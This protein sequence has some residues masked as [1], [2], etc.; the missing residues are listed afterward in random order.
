MGDDLAERDAHGEEIAKER[1]NLGHEERSGDSFTGD[2]A[3]EEVE[4]AVV[5]DEIAVVATDGAEGSV[6]IAGVPSAGAEIGRWE[7]FVLK[8]SGE[9]E[10]ALQGVA[11]GFVEVVDAVTDEWVREQ[12]I[13]FDGVVALF[14][15]AEGAGGDAVESGVDFTQERL[16]IFV[17]GSVRDRGL[18]A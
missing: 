11:L 2:V 16:E 14:A 12:A 10:V 1:V 18:Q 17:V 13:L 6:V 9:I 15:E 4:R 5:L 7:Q 8:L 3:E